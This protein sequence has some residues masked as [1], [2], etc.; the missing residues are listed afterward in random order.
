MEGLDSARLGTVSSLPI[1]VRSDSNS[2]NSGDSQK[3]DREEALE[4]IR[5]G[6]PL[7]HARSS[8]SV[9][10]SGLFSP[11]SLPS[12]I[13]FVS[14]LGPVGYG[15]TTLPLRHSDFVETLPAKT[16]G[17]AFLMT[18][19]SE[20]EPLKSPVRCPIAH[21]DQHSSLQGKAKAT[22]V[23]SRLNICTNLHC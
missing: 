22:E 1:L 5:P 10:S 2:T 6:H 12:S 21:K 23:I 18:G 4:L 7:K 16:E 15:P 17:N 20:L 8:D 19:L 13:N 9:A 14:I 11:F 3:R